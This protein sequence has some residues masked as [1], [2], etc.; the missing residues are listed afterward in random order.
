MLGLFSHGGSGKTSLAEALLHRAGAT[1][2]LGRVEE[3]TTVTDHEPEEQRHRVSI[4]LAA[5]YA[6][7]REHLLQLLDAPGY[8]E[9]AGEA[10]AALR[11]VDAA[12]FPVD[13]TAAVGAS[14]ES[15]WAAAAERSLPRVVFVNKL[16]RENANFERTLQELSTALG[17]KLLPVT[18]PVGEQAALSGVVDLVR[19]EVHLGTGTGPV[20]AGLA[21][22]AQE[23]HRELVEAAAEQDDELLARYLEGEE[24]TPQEVHRGLAAG[25][26]AGKL[27]PV[28]CGSALNGVGVSELL[29]AAVDLLPGPSA[30][31]TEGGELCRPLAAEPVSALVF[32]TTADPY[33]G[34]LTLFR[35][36]SGTLRSDSHVLNASRRHEERLGQLFILQGKRQ[37]PAAEAGPGSIAAVAKLQDT[38]T[39]DTLCA[40]E[41][42]VVFPGIDFPEPVHMA[43][44]VPHSKADEDKIG[45]GLARLMEE[46][47]TLHLE[48]EPSTGQLLLRGMGELHL[49]IARE[50]LLRK[51]GV[52]V[53][54]A[55][56]R[57]PYRE[58]IRAT[59]KVEGKYKKQT[60]GRGQY[61]HVWL[62]LAP[63]PEEQFTFV[64]KI[65][66]G[67]VP[68]QYRPA[69]EKGVRETM[70]G[71][72][73]AGYPVTNVQVT[74]YDGSYHS[75]DS[76][77]MAFKI[78]A[79]M[80]FKKGMLQASPV[81]LEPI[82]RVE[83]AVPEEYMGDC[84]A[85]LNRRR[86]K[87]LG[88][89]SR[90]SQQL[91]RAQVPLAEMFHYV[92]DLRALSQGRGGYRMEFHGY[93]EVPPQVA[94]GILEEAKVGTEATH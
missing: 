66:G 31:T 64:D 87:I 93:E 86:G 65:F 81:L 11:V 32:K 40:A 9:F 85:D 89:E 73:L 46:D 91:V 23:L 53:D 74:L 17:R 58:T 88:M 5:A 10:R 2:R 15:L 12:V 48:K 34:K 4:S 54:L 79:S 47:P 41:R 45:A 36:Y 7:W 14:T 39:G 21:E 43:A 60:G 38:R 75:V 16:D 33:V 27:I 83:V 90:G 71:G 28:L 42:A 67:V 19:L 92:A 84:I 56:P 80:A 49:D 63:L 8:C 22:R 82:Y 62:E 59:A 13:A 55:E 72:V 24:L 20:P 26:A 52:A 51:F 25:T 76:S 78:A 6:R 68:Q 94:Q 50:R 1:E 70:A 35:V 44:V 3:G 77:E 61:G 18:L 37:E 69:V 29:D 30:A 57:V